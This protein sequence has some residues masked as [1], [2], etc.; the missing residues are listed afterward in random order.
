MNQLLENIL[1]QGQSFVIYKLPKTDDF[2]L[3]YGILEESELVQNQENFIISSFKGNIYSFKDNRRITL[4]PDGLDELFKEIDL[5]DHLS[6][7]PGLKSTEQKD[8]TDFVQ[9]SVTEITNEQY[10]KI[11]PT[12]IKVS[13][14][15]I[16]SIPETLRSLASSYPET[17]VSFVFSIKVG[18]WVGA[19][20]EVLL[21][22]NETE[23]KTVAL[24]GTQL[25][26]NLTTKQASW[27][28]KEIEEQALVSRYIIDCFKKIR[29]R[30]Y[31][32]TGPKT[33]QTGKLFHLKTDY[34]IKKSDTDIENLEHKLLE[35]LHPTSAVCGMPKN[36]TQPI[37][38]ERE[39]HDRTLY[40][41]FWGPVTET[42]FNFYVNIRLA[43]LF[44]EKI[45]FYAG[46]GITEDSDPEAEWKET[47]AKCDNLALKLIN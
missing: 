35:L 19:S 3:I 18:C 4:T 34:H 2:I 8:F 42:G 24:A 37:I 15:H 28:Q 39:K 22:A 17:L 31:T 12:K 16:D 1:Q 33:M 5:N 41:G 25:A 6:S 14:N 13:K 29:L 30:E 7:N 20:P 11:V 23:V 32:E 45:V 9:Q 10:H 40:T 21:Q 27:S 36:I 44:K 38:L 43:Q 46:A 47:E 26:G